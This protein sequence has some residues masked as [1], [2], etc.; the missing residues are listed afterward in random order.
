MNNDLKLSI[1]IVVYRSDLDVFTHSLNALHVAVMNAAGSRSLQVEL[2]I[3]DNS[4]DPAW[5]PRLEAAAGKAFPANRAIR[6]EVIVSPKNVGYGSANNLAICKVASDY[7]LVMNPDVCVDPFAIDHALEYMEQNRNA[8]LLVPDV[9]GEDGIRHYLCKRDPTL[10]I[11]TLRGFGP[12][13]LNR[14][15]LR[16]LNHFE[17]R[18]RDHERDIHDVEFPTGCFMFFRTLLLKTIG[19]FDPRFFLY[20]EDADVGR[21]MRQVAPIHYVPQ[22]RIVHRWTRGF[23]NSWYLRW[24]IVKSGIIYFRKWAPPEDKTR[25]NAKMQSARP[26]LRCGSNPHEPGLESDILDQAVSRVECLAGS[27][28]E[29]IK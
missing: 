25:R 9:R 26:P 4:C 8:G 28:R 1:S 5:R 2:Y 24:C 21:E 6:S 11:M 22:V 18:D 20:F 23:R 17:M 12:S 3:V 27:I 13:W 19:G 16:K 7:H 10:F 15:F 14:L 29:R